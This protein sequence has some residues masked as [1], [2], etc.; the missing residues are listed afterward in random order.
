M[1]SSHDFTTPWRADQQTIEHY[2]KHT[3]MDQAKKHL[4]EVTTKRYT[5][6]ISQSATGGM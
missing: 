4:Y 6:A 5:M 2:A 1:E 3:L